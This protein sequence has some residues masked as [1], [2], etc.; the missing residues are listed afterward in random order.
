MYLGAFIMEY[1]LFLAAYRW[2][3]RKASEYAE[4]PVS[5]RFIEG[6]F[7]PSSP[8]PPAITSLTSSRCVLSLVKSVIR[9][10]QH[11]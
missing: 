1:D 8:S 4:T 2:A 3:A 6:W 7:A 10:A 11:R 9:I 5:E